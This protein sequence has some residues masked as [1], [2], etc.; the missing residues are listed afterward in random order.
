M[1]TRTICAAY[2]RNEL[3]LNV[4]IHVNV[5][6]FIVAKFIV[7][8]FIYL[9]DLLRYTFELKRLVVYGL[10]NIIKTHRILIYTLFLSW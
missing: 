10:K 9:S 1:C 3:Q 6:L 7:F 5:T 2:C 4:Y 8:I